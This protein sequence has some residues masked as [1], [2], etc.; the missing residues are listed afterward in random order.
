[1]NFGSKYLGDEIMVIL[2]ATSYG[3]TH[4]KPADSSQ[5]LSKN[6]HFKN[7]SREE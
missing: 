6:F 7:D 1:M 3:V 4:Y 5:L 2:P